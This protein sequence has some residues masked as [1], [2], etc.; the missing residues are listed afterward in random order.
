MSVTAVIVVNHIVLWVFEHIFL[1]S[2]EGELCNIPVNKVLRWVSQMG[3]ERFMRSSE[4][5]WFTLAD[6]GSCL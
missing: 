2:T 3:N 5:P 4:W 6:S 1:Y